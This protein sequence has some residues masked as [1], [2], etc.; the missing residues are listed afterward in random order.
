MNGL[1][2]VVGVERA[3]VQTSDESHPIECAFHWQRRTQAS[4]KVLVVLDVND[5]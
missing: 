2:A 1:R 4:G 5:R 3:S